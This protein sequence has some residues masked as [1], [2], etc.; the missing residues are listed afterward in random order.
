MRNY[1]LTVVW[2]ISIISSGL[3]PAGPTSELTKKQMKGDLDFI[4]NTLEVHYAPAS[5]KNSHV[6][7]D[8][9]REIALAKA[10]IDDSRE[11][12][13]KNYHVLVRDFF[14][15]MQDHHVSVEFFSTESA[16]LPF[17]IKSAEGRYF[18]N[19]I[20]KLRLNS[21]AY[22]LEVGDEIVTFDDRPIKEAVE[23]VAK[24]ELAG[25]NEPT[26]RAFAEM[27]LTKRFGRLAHI[28]PRGPVTI[29]V[30]KKGS[31]KVV[32]V[33]LVWSYIPERVE[34]HYFVEEEELEEGKLP[35]AENAFFHNTYLCPYY[36]F[37]VEPSKTASANPHAM[38]AKTNY[39]PLLGKKLWQNA[40]DSTF[41][42]YTFELNKDYR[43]GYIRIP[44]YLGRDKEAQE[45]AECIKFFEEMTDALVI[46]Q[47]NNPGGKLFYMCA[48]A[49]MLTDQPLFN[50][51]ARVAITPKEVAAAAR[52]IPLLEEITDDAD[53][54]EVLG[55][56]LQGY[57]V[58]YQTS[59]FFLEYCRFV[60]NE[61][62][63]GRTLTNPHFLYGL[64]KINPKLEAHYTKPI[65]VLVNELS[66]SCG[67]FLPAIL[68]DNN[69][70]KIMGAKTAGAGG[71][72]RSTE[73]PNRFG[74]AK[75]KYTGSIAER[76]N[77]QP[78]E[79]LGV[80]PDIPYTITIAD[81]RNQYVDYAQAINSALRELLAETQK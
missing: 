70:A 71:F 42:A 28:V 62:K 79:N 5:W 53:A 12:S 51:K 26:D 59:Q 78:I 4:R 25:Q 16:S 67:D 33:Q 56:S 34:N 61:W 54:E 27:F 19:Y 68:Q 32:N 46:D 64:D 14:K 21:T 43:I 2:G 23:H 65:L 17:S 45:F 48:L 40:S 39:L 49:S 22:P 81:L 73:F 37:M 8:L 77:K 52:Y 10:K 72:V 66:F 80:T 35:L 24:T 9:D 60:V 58:N 6:G 31:D 57:P 15:S 74:I 38:G 47:L 55:Q 13:M 3:L 50:P 69:R 41:H 29:G 63:E 11:I 44:H 30:I 7:W 20:N 36:N 1:L 75:F 76:R 18:I